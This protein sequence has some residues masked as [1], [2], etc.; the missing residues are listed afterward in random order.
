MR[1]WLVLLFIASVLW[2]CQSKQQVPDGIIAPDKMEAVLFDMLRSGNLINNFLLAKD[3]SLPKEQTQ[4]DWINKV[5][6]F[7]EVSEQQ[8]KESFTYYQHHPALMAQIMDSISKIEEDPL[9]K[10]T[11]PG[12]LLPAQ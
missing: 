5:L 4:I 1:G 12:K 10:I 8:F 7:H 2:G 6:I 11:K 3:S 9:I